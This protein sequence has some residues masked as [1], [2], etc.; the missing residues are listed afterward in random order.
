MSDLSHGAVPVNTTQ[1]NA[2]TVEM[3][4]L[5]LATGA[6]EAYQKVSG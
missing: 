1:P 2:K 4:A 3:V 5:G 6:Y